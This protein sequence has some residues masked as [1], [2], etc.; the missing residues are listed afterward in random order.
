MIEQSK[1]GVNFRQAK[2]PPMTRLLSAPKAQTGRIR[3][4][5][6]ILIR[7]IAVGGQITTI[8]FV[9]AVLAGLALDVFSHGILGV[10]GISLFASAFAAIYVGNSM[11]E[12]SLLFVV[13]AV[14]GLSLFEGVVSISIFELLDSSTPWWNWFLTRS[15]P[16]SI[17][18]GLL[19][20]VLLWGM[21]RL[22]RW[23]KLGDVV[24]IR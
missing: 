22:E 13:T 17:Y 19:A 8:L 16:V 5:T 4:R 9:Y 11:Y 15:L 7:W 24:G 2:A 10:Y 18:H 20:P 21:V 23:L 6:L 12:N 3:L 1:F 14:A